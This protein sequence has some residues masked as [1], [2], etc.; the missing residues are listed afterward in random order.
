MHVAS[1]TQASPEAGQEERLLLLLLMCLSAELSLARRQQRE[2]VLLVWAAA[3]LSIPAVHQRVNVFFRGMAEPVQGSSWDCVVDTLL[4]LEAKPNPIV[5]GQC[6]PALP[7]VLVFLP[8][9]T[10]SYQA[11]WHHIGIFT[12]DPGMWRG[13]LIKVALGSCSN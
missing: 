3:I 1:C 4:A 11:L 10:V 6:K 5:Q 13:A 8:W 7:L 9:G 12:R 2:N